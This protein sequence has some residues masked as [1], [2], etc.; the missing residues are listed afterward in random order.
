MLALDR[1]R[2]F[3]PW[4]L[5]AMIAYLLLYINDISYVF[6][7]TQGDALATFSMS[8]AM[9]MTAYIMPLLAALPFSTGFCSDWSSG[10]TGAVTLR[11]GR[12]KYFT[13]KIIACALSGGLAAAGG[14]LLLILILVLKFP[15]TE[16]IILNFIDVGEFYDILAMPGITGLV[17]YYAGVVFMQFL[18]GSFWAMTG[19]AFSAFCPN[20][21]LTLCIP[22]AAYR[23]CLELYYWVEFPQWLCPPLLQDLSVELSYWPTLLIGLGV[24]LVLNIL[25][26]ALFAWRAGRRLRYAQ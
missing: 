21:L 15:H 25:L 5:V 4:L 14:T 18:A 13:S 8:G 6:M 7:D 17:L 12:K 23:L 26:A 20:F 19:L 10:F 22:L 24:F 2:A 9:G 1:R 11:S 3:G 16:E